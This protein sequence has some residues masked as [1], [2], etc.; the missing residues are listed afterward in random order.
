MIS[1]ATLQFLATQR[2]RDAEV[3]YRNN[4]RA[5]AVYLIGYAVEL[6]LKRKICRTLGFNNGFPENSLEFDSY[7][8]QIDSFNAI[9]TGL[10]LN[11]LKQIKSHDLNMLVKFSGAEGRIINHLYSK[12]ILIKDW[13]PEYRYKRTAYTIAKSKQYMRAAKEILKQI[14]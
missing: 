12:W 8:S 14:R 7:T 10:T 1:I 2:L 11:K 3:L 9:S 13:N 5:A 6:S 4:R